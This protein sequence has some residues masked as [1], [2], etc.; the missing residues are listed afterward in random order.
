MA[1]LLTPSSNRSTLFLMRLS[2]DIKPYHVRVVSGW[3][4][5]LSAGWFASMFFVRPLWLLTTTFLAS[6]LCLYVAFLL[7]RLLDTYE[8]H[9]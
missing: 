8:S 1:N 6:I 5:N 2:F 7:E 9:S 4:V 3:L